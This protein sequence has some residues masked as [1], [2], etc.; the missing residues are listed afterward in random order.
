MT[1][2]MH[3]TGNYVF[4]PRFDAW[5]II[6][7][8]IFHCMRLGGGTQSYGSGWLGNGEDNIC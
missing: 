3:I 1:P 2:L 8:A 4:R 5:R 7:G 6:T